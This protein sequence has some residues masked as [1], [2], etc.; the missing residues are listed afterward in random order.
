[1]IE[2]K[3]LHKSFGKLEVLK[4]IDLNISSGEITTFL[5]PSGAGKT[6]LLQVLGTLMPPDV[7]QVLY[8]GK[9]V[10]G[11]SDKML[12]EFRNRHIGFVFQFHQLLSEFSAA[13][14]VMLPA[15][16][17]GTSKKDARKRSEELLSLLGL[18]DRINHKPSQLSGGEAQRVA[19]AR[20]LI[21]NPGVV[22]AD[23][24]TGSLDPQNRLEIQNLF[25]SLC[26]EFGH[27]FVIVTHDLSLASIAHRV[28]KMD[29]GIIISD[30]STGKMS[31]QEGMKDVIEMKEEFSGEKPDMEDS[32]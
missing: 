1:M 7:G 14:N 15:L 13:E 9:D 31:N 12:S 20:A 21:N 6:T 18:S 17:G 4:G 28:I 32:D 23:E 16:I 26:E 3:N 2:A 5:G 19:V 29:D 25:A 22:F 27:T 24:P 30:E 8:E 11:L 10:T